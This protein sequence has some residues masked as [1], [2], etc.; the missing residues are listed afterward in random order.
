[1]MDMN[2]KQRGARSV[3][4]TPQCRLDMIDVIEAISFVDVDD[5][6]NARTTHAISNNEMIAPRIRG[7]DTGIPFSG[8]T[9]RPQALPR[10]QE[11][12]LAHAVLPN[13][14]A[15]RRRAGAAEAIAADR[16]NLGRSEAAK[17]N[18]HKLFGDQADFSNS[19]KPRH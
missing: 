1:M 9:W 10:S 4:A 3:D 16:S 17:P 6:M 11:G 5:E 13:Q 19:I 12:V 14:R 8:G 2:M 15:N 7:H 18:K